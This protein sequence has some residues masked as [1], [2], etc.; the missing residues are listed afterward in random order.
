MELQLCIFDSDVSFVQGIKAI[1][2]TK[3]ISTQS[4]LEYFDRDFQKLVDHLATPIWGNKQQIILC[5]IASLPEARFKALSLL[6]NQ[7]LKGEQRQ[8]I[9][10]VEEGQVPL[11]S[12]LFTELP[13][14]SWFC[15]KEPPQEL[16]NMLEHL[17][18]TS[19]SAPYYSS[20]IRKSIEHYRNQAFSVPRYGITHTE[21][22]L[23]EEI[24]KGQSLTQIALNSGISVK[25]VSYRKRRLMKKLN[26][27][28]TVSLAQT[29]RHLTGFA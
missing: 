15:K 14:A 26:V 17:R 25:S 3:N 12:A 13:L 27:T 4:T 28:S 20:M 24:L 22:W 6:R 8:L 18:L 16:V 21:W 23:M 29:F 11:L 9:M 10:L 1:I 7:Y 2:D 19:F 5:D